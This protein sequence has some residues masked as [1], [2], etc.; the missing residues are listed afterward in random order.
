MTLSILLAEDN[1]VIHGIMADLLRSEGHHVDVAG[2]GVEAI[3]R[4]NGTTIYDLFLLD[5]YLPRLSGL[6]V[7][8]TLRTT[9]Q[10]RETP[11]LMLS[12]D[13]A[14]E[15]RNECL[16]AGANDYL[17]KPLPPIALLDLVAQYDRPN[18]TMP[19]VSSPEDSTLIDDTVIQDLAIALASEKKLHRIIHNFICTT[20]SQIHEMQQHDIRQ[21][22]QKLRSIIHSMKGSAG[23]FGAERL[24]Q[25]CR[26]LEGMELPQLTADL[27]QLAALV[28]ETIAKLEQLM[29]R[30]II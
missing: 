2:N 29:D 30:H 18:G 13:H 14:D 20:R 8:K 5:L 10:Y 17:L 11:V 26:I 6:E 4:I 16:A 23:M 1:P 12:G 3:E 28:D 9:D 7:L 19:N 25:Q 21:D 27:P 22:R 15:S 24:M